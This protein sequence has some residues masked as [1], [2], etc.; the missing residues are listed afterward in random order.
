MQGPTTDKNEQGEH[1]WENVGGAA[2][3]KIAEEAETHL[4]QEDGENALVNGIRKRRRLRTRNDVAGGR[5]VIR[6]MIRYVYLVIDMSAAMAE[7]DS[8]LGGGTRLHSTVLLASQF[9]LEFFDQ[10][11]I[12]HLGLVIAKDGEA[13]LLTQLSGNP[14]VHVQALAR[15]ATHGSSGGDFSLQNALEV[16]GRSLGHMPSYGSREIM[17]LCGALSTCDPGDIL[18]ETLP[19]L[20]QAGVMIS[21]ISLAAEMY[22]C[23]RIAEE[24]HGT[25]NVCLGKSHYHDLLMSK[26]TPPPVLLGG[27]KKR[28]C[29]FVEMGFPTRETSEFP[30]LI[31]VTKDRKLFARTGY[32]CPRCNAKASE[33]PTDCTVCGLKLVLAPHL[34]R[35]FHHLFPVSLFVELPHDNSAATKLHDASV[36]FSSKDCQDSC[37]GCLKYIGVPPTT[38]P[39]KSGKK[40]FTSNNLTDES[41]PGAILRFQCPDCKNIFCADCDIYLHEE[42]H[43]CP[44]CL[45]KG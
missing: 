2:W 14:K 6:E 5:R 25:M 41:T 30:S 44:G 38:K 39:K 11:P 18:M 8:S 13:E 10:N 43:N 29:D 32:K 23:R 28:I 15:T 7:K 19:K 17:V 42:L 26:C 16:A 34:A 33:L 9:L 35:S 3:T 20:K 22:V 27:T 12:S 21:F 45:C 40:D 37:F 1:S 36:L 24:T 4:R 31:H